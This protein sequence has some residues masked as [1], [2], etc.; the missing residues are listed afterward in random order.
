ME[1]EKNTR[2]YPYIFRYNHWYIRFKPEISLFLPNILINNT[3]LL[4]FLGIN[5]GQLVTQ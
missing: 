3:G 4:R 2:L 1:K 5:H